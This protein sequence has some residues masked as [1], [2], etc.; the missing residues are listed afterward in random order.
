MGQGSGAEVQKIRTRIQQTQSPE[1]KFQ[2][3]SQI[4]LSFSREELDSAKH[5]FTK[6][7]ALARTLDDDSLLVVTYYLE[8]V[9]RMAANEVQ[10]M[11]DRFMPLLEQESSSDILAILNLNLFK[12]YQAQGD[13]D[14]SLF[15]ITKANEHFVNKK[16]K[17]FS[18]SFL[19]VTGD[20]YLNSGEYLEALN[21]YQQAFELVENGNAKVKSNVF[22]SL[23]VIY[24]VLDFHDQA[25]DL[26][27]QDLEFCLTTGD[28]Y[29]A[30][31]SYFLLGESQFHLERFDQALNSARKAI[32]ISEE[33]GISTSIGFAYYQ[34]GR[35]FLEEKQLDSV[36]WYAE[37]GRKISEENGDRKE[38]GECKSL[39]A[40]YLILTGKYQEALQVCDEVL[41]MDIYVG[42]NYVIYDLKARAYEQLG[43]FEEAYKYQKVKENLDLT[44]MADK[45]VR[46]LA[47]N[48][49]DKS[50]EEGEKIAQLEY[51]KN[52]AKW[53][54]IGIIIFGGL[55]LVFII[56]FFNYKNRTTSRQNQYLAK[57][58]GSLESRNEAL[59]KFTFMTSHDLL[60]PVRVI[61]SMSGLL[62][63]KLKEGDSPQ[64]LE[65]LAFIQDSVKSL[66]VMTSGV[67]EYAEAL[68][69]EPVW[70]LFSL[71]SL[72]E[73]LLKWS[74]D[75]YPS[76]QLEFH[77]DKEIDLIT[78]PRSQLVRICE[79]LI[80]NSIEA[81]PGKEDLQ[82]ILTASTEEQ[83]IL[84][85]VQDNGTGIKPDYQALIFQPFESLENKLLTQRSGL[86]LSICAMLVENNGGSIWLD[87]AY[88]DGAKFSFTV[89]LK[90]SELIES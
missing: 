8:G 3:L 47:K 58:N 9:R 56:I 21:A 87:T 7:E 43:A 31:Y 27:K 42:L 10:G 52:V 74:Y 44:L 76:L 77:F 23:S 67:R 29:G 70:N 40:E 80:A 63:R 4:A 89:P 49:M 69:P 12:A 33:I 60:E 90:N 83:Q 34:V 38:E 36:K 35:I 72:K 45:P 13:Q 64:N 84:F 79:H 11:L 86:G 81:N 59:K 41:E 68:E 30:M 78:Y 66:S 48:F 61:G 65:K 85:S 22:Q 5:Y 54:Y 1:Q 28:K 46:Q 57:I 25:I 88:S 73:E 82:C 24:Q 26:A 75:T 71:L 14:K 51:E 55:S 50:Y 15:F 32:D 6:M 18:V 53:Q 16:Y 19:L 2:Y 17:A 37:M 39:L 62:K 20:F